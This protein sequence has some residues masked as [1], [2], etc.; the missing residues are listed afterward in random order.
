[1][2]MYF[3]AFVVVGLVWLWLAGGSFYAWRQRSLPGFWSFASIA[4]VTGIAGAIILFALP[5]W[6]V[7]YRVLIQPG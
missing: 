4:V 5:Y 6:V 1:M 3:W 7:V 2:T